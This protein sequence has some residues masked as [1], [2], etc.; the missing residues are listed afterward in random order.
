MGLTVD[1]LPF[2]DLEHPASHRI[3]P[4]FAC[5]YR[6]GIFRIPDP[7]QRLATGTAEA[8]ALLPLVLRKALLADLAA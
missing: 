8:L 3:I 2:T 1:S 4:S 6:I 5:R 7:C